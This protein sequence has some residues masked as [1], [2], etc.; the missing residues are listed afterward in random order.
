VKNSQILLL[1]LFILL[2]SCNFEKNNQEELNTQTETSAATPPTISA[3]QEAQFNTLP[4]IKGKGIGGDSLSVRSID[5]KYI[6]VEFWAS[7]CPPCRGFNP[8]LV[9]VYDRFHANG[10]EIFSISLDQEPSK[11]QGA[12]KKDNLHWPYHICEFKGWDSYW[13]KQYNIESIPNNILF[14]KNGNIIARGMEPAQLA[15]LLETLK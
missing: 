8:E 13:A 15:K 3:E 10:F 2:T 1:G 12:V 14:D 7:W 5:A 6:L 4:D 11:W 9:R